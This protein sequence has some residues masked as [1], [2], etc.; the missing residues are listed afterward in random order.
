[1]STQ[2]NIGRILPIFK[3]QWNSATTYTKLD[4]V[5][6]EGCSWV[7]LRGNTNVEPNQ[8]NNS[9]WLMVASKGSW[10]NFTPSEKEELIQALIPYIDAEDVGLTS[11]K[12][13]STDVKG[14]LEE[15]YEDID[16]LAFRTEDIE[17]NKIDDNDE[18]IIVKDA[19]NNNVVEIT[20][21]GVDAKNLKSNGKNVVTE[22]EL[23]L[24]ATKEEL[25]GKQDE[26]DDI[27]Q[28][29]EAIQTSTIEFRDDEDNYV[30][31]ISSQAIAAKKFLI[32]Q[33]PNDEGV[34]ITRAVG[35]SIAK[36]LGLS[37]VIHVLGVG[38]SLM[39]GTNSGAPVTTT[40]NRSNLF[41]FV[42]GVRPWDLLDLDYKKRAHLNRKDGVNPTYLEMSDLKDVCLKSTDIGYINES[43]GS[44]VPLTEKIQKYTANGEIYNADSNG[45]VENN[46]KDGETPLAG[47]CE[48][49]LN[50]L[51]ASYGNNFGFE[52]IAT[53][54]GYGSANF[55]SLL[56]LDRDGRIHNYTDNP[57]DD[58]TNMNY[59][60]VLLMSVKAAKAI[61]D[62]QN[63]TYSADVVIYKESNTITSV[64]NVSLT[65]PLKA[66]RIAQ[67]F[68]LINQRVKAITKQSND[69]IF[70]CDQSKTMMS[71]REAI[72]ILGVENEIVLSTAEVNTLKTLPNYDIEP[73]DLSKIHLI[74]STN[75]YLIGSDRIHHPSLAQK[76]EGA[77]IGGAY[78]K[79]LTKQGFHPVYPI[80]FKI[81]GNDIYIKYS[82][83]VSPIVIDADAV[84]GNQRCSNYMNGQ[85][86]YGFGFF[87][88]IKYEFQLDG[89]Y[90]LAV[91]DKYRCKYSTNSY[92]TYTIIEKREENGRTIIIASGTSQYQSVIETTLTKSSGSGDDTLT[93]T[94]MVEKSYIDF[95]QS[96]VVS[97]P[98]TIK[99][100]CKG[101]PSD[102]VLEYC[103]KPIPSPTPT[104]VGDVLPTNCEFG[105][106]RDS[107]GDVTKINVNN[108]EYPLHN[109]AIGYMKKL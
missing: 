90:N 4:V 14:G 40:Q 89:I 69:I 100:T 48:G 103:Y 36:Q 27:E 24:L 81:I 105:N 38:Q 53:S 97:E 13:S 33:N 47:F 50:A 59:F 10:S 85:G 71:Q 49:F 31:E 1:M 76:I 61:A 17:Q 109:W 20:S 30:G 95:I 55:L 26:I 84:N 106:I 78:Q 80:N 42:G 92:Y 77:T 73:Y 52:M 19:Q 94:S 82:V 60:E 41:R 91:G 5:L 65:V 15:L 64:P 44:L 12:L 6:Q 57:N 8:S 2:I 68:T 9:D 37:D 75:N 34:D 46:H 21:N 66:Y 25:E 3:G 62:A 86:L 23:A 43:I 93:F 16:E 96:I 58:G 29:E 45:T 11:T 74:V 56:P 70:L 32:K 35:V 107:Q 39:S 101:D 28:T 22:D 54:C 108:T 87:D 72:R 79:I 18:S 63:K 51:E 102:K 7:A 99:I 83:P 98:D 88:G 104:T 67:L